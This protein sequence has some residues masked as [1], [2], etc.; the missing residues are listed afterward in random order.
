MSLQDKPG[1]EGD[2]PV[3]IATRPALPGDFD[4]CR[5]LYFSSMRPLLEAL[6]TWDEAKAER[7]FKD[8]FKPEEIRIV[9]VD[10]R[11]AG[12]IQVSQTESE[13]HLDQIHLNEETRGRGIGTKLISETMADARSAGKPVLL[14]LLR[15]NR[16]ISLYRRL[17]FKPN[18]SDRTKLHMRWNGR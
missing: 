12:W 7:T 18:G 8:Y 6:G 5:A 14:S 15:G 9:I 13:V 4:F 16:A 10:G 1:A 17:G 2:A 11:E 3:P